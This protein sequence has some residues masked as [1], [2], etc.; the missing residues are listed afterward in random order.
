MG[1]IDPL[2]SRLTG[3]TLNV[4]Y[5]QRPNLTCES[6]DLDEG[7]LHRDVL[8]EFEK[9]KLRVD[10]F[11][12]TPTLNLPALD[13]QELVQYSAELETV[14]RQFLSDVR[15]A[16][17]Y[18]DCGSIG[19]CQLCTKAG[20]TPILGERGIKDYYHPEGEA[21][22]ATDDELDAICMD[23]WVDQ[24]PSYFFGHYLVVYGLKADDD[25][26]H[27]A[28]NRFYAKRQR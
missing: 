11:Y 8:F 7:W 6:R 2:A 22:E 13:K 18:L 15:K 3:M 20:A 25:R 23:C 1:Y 14:A 24:E 28:W 10:L 5:S 9:G 17:C 12:N 16:P 19:K 26:I 27:A 4:S 21:R